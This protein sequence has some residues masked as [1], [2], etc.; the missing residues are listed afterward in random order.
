MDIHKYLESDLS[1]EKC[2][3]KS[4][5]WLIVSLVSVSDIT[6][7]ENNV[8]KSD[9]VSQLLQKAMYCIWSSSAKS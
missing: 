6:E 9:E 8:L 1:T 4:H 7:P 5:I 3:T 2:T